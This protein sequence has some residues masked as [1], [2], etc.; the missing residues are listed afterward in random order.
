MFIV[1]LRF[2]GNKDQAG[3]FM[4]GHKEWLKRGFDDGVFLSA[5]SLQ[6]NLGGRIVAHNSSLPDLQTWVND[7]PF[8]AENVVGAEI[9]EIEPSKTDGRLEFLLS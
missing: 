5:G 3:Q 9:L 7:D 6:P 2:S 1:L 4:D 8:V